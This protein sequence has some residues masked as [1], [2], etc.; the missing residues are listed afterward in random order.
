M[1]AAPTASTGPVGAS[2]SSAGGRVQRVDGVDRLLDPDDADA[3]AGDAVDGGVGDRRAADAAGHAGRDAA[4]LDG[5][6]VGDRCR[7]ARCSSRR[8]R[9]CDVKTHVSPTSRMPLPFVSPLDVDRA[10]VVGRVGRRAVVVDQRCDHEARRSAVLVRVLRD[11]R[12]LVRPPDARAGRERR[13]RA[14]R[15]RPSCRWTVPS[16][17]QRSFVMWIAGVKSQAHERLP[18]PVSSRWTPPMLPGCGSRG[19]PWLSCHRP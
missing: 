12:D 11:V 16:A 4:G 13:R 8:G 5:D 17:V 15:P 7:R 14:C 10:E 9:P 3:G 18:V 2:A 19:P 1:I 6:G